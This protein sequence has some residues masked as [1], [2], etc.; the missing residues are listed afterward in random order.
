MFLLTAIYSLG[1]SGQTETTDDE[2]EKPSLSVA[3]Y[4]REIKVMGVESF[5]IFDLAGKDVTSKNGELN[6]GIYIVYANGTA[7]KVAVKG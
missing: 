4:G 3:V 2:E 5:L 1:L 7:L 6:T